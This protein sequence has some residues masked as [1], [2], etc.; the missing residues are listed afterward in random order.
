MEENDEESQKSFCLS[1]GRD[2]SHHCV[3]Q[4]QQKME[5]SHSING[6]KRDPANGMRIEEEEEEMREERSARR[7][8]R[9]A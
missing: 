9:R 3:Q 4:Q 5:K 7:G 8:R 1:V 6:E 2:G